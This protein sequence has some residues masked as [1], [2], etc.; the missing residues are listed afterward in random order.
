VVQEV[1]QHPEPEG[2]GVTRPEVKE[3]VRIHPF[4]ISAKLNDCSADELKDVFV[5][6]EPDQHG[7]PEWYIQFGNTKY[8]ET[9]E[10]PPQTEYGKQAQGLYVRPFYPTK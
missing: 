4:D 2:R 10:V 8:I 1:V 5:F 7:Q 9:T 3:T 6:T